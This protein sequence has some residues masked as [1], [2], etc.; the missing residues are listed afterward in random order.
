MKMFEQARV[1]PNLRPLKDQVVGDV[2]KFLWVLMAVIGIVLLIA[3][4][5]VANLLLVRTEGRQQELAIRTALG[6]SRGRIASV[7]LFES[8]VIGL[9]GGALGV[10]LAAAGLRLLVAIGPSG[11]PRLAEISIDLRA[12]S[13][14]LVASLLSSFFFGLIPVFKYTGTRIGVSLR[15][16]GRTASQSRERHRTRDVLVITQVALAIVLLVSAGL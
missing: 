5:N 1:G 15:G 14:A 4:A 10:G 12:L 6:A 8:L 3:C 16:G 13:F 7:L 11:L 9:M 2:G